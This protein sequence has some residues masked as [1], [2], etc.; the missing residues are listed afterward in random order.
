MVFKT[1]IQGRLLGMRMVFSKGLRVSST[2]YSLVFSVG[3]SVNKHAVAQEELGALVA[4]ANR[5]S[6]VTLVD[7]KSG[8]TR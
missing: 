6:H 2:Y 1:E 8:S 7:L 3:E 5:S 4:V